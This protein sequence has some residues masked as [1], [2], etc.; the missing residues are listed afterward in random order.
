MFWEEI[1]A[2][3]FT[4]GGIWSLA[5]IV[6]IMILGYVGVKRILTPS[7]T[8]ERENYLAQKDN[9]R[10]GKT[11]ARRYAEVG[12]IWVFN[13]IIVVAFLVILYMIFK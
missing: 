11:M 9:I 8:I 12:F 4:F 1:L 3:W 10:I 5:L 7:N 13:F 6:V 2:I